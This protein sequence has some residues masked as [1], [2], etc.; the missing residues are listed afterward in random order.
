[1]LLTIQESQKLPDNKVWTNRFQIKSSSSNQLYVVAQNKT[2]R[3]WGCG[4]KG[5]IY[6]RN[7]K[8]LQ[9]LGLPAN[10][11]P[12]EVTVQTKRKVLELE[13]SI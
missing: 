13:Y 7:C 1:M 4:C 6:H 2:S 9:T 3:G 8:H 12:M 10:L 5:W 11:R